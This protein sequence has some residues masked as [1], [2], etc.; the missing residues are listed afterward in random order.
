MR[1]LTR[2]GIRSQPL[3]DWALRVMA[4]LLRE[5][6]SLGP[7]RVYRLIAQVAERAPERMASVPQRKSTR[8]DQIRSAR[9]NS[10]V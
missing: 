8:A 10:R 5:D 4:N 3:M 7:E 6:E 1:E 9:P 2:V